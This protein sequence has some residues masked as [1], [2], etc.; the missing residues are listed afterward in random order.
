MP[1][2][3]PIVLSHEIVGRLTKVG[4]R[5]SIDFILETVPAIN[6][7]T[8]IYLLALDGNLTIVGAP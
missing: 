5:C 7:T 8:I 2:V 1:T 4:S 3:Y 6:D